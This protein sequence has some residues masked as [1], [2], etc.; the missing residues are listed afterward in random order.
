MAPTNQL[1]RGGRLS[2]REVQCLQGAARGLTNA[3]IAEEL[4]ISV[5]SVKTHMKRAVVKLGAR[6]GNAIPNVTRAHAVALAYEYGLLTPAGRHGDHAGYTR[7]IRRGED[8]RDC[9]YGCHDAE[10]A[11]R[12]RLRA[13]ATTT[14]GKA[15]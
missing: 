2:P 4:W 7:H 13:R 6:T 1:H 14:K 11:Y 10:L 8:P 3:E 9:P 5:D 12:A 15:R